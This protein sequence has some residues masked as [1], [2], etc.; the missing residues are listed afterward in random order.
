MVEKYFF[1]EYA[2][3]ELWYH[4]AMIGVGWKVEREGVLKSLH[5]KKCGNL[6][7]TFREAK[8]SK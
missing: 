5:E 6:L 2:I 3:L 1:Q 4:L 7:D 8:F